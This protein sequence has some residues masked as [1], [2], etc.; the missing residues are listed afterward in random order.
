MFARS[1]PR[2]FLGENGRSGDVLFSAIVGVLWLAGSYH[3]VATNP[4]ADWLPEVLLTG[5]C[6]GLAEEIVF[7]GVLFPTL[8]TEEG[9]AR[10]VS[11]LDRVRR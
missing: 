1:I 5:V 7:S 11:G 4:H 8:I 10:E 3:V 2:Y 9:M 6:A